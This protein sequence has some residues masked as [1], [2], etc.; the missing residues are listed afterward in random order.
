MRPLRRRLAPLA[1]L[2]LAAPVRAENVE[3][4]FEDVDGLRRGYTVLRV[5]GTPQERG[6]ALGTT[7][8]QELTA[9]LPK[10]RALPGY[11]WS[12]QVASQASWPAEVA[13][14]LAAMA[15]GIR[16]AAPGSTVTLA[17]LQTLNGLDWTFGD[18]CRSHSCWGRYVE[19]PV[20][21][22]ST[23]RL[24]LETPFDL[25]LHHVVVLFE[26]DSGPRW[27]NVAWPGFVTAITAVDARGTLVSL[28]DFEGTQVAR[29][30]VTFRGIA[31]RQALTSPAAG[32]AAARRD[33]AAALLS[34]LPLATS[35][36]LNYYAPE[37]EGGVFTCAAGVGCAAPRRPQPGYFSG[38][39][40]VTSNSQTD[41]WSVPA[42]AEFIDAYYRQGGVKRLADHFALMGGSGLHLV[43]VEYRAESDLTVW[44]HGRGRGDVLR[45]EWGSA[46]V[47]VDTVA[48]KGCGCGEGGAPLPIFAAAALSLGLVRARRASIP[49]GAGPG[50]VGD[51]RAGARRSPRTCR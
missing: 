44:I 41:G 20:R 42:G 6:R 47:G 46:G 17:D 7:F 40:L 16:A 23:R 43:S 9:E 49:A 12:A 37:G 29:P 27:L 14:E 11:A 18:A 30:G 2:L 24:D 50:A 4:L 1:V 13:E 45:L 15:E 33:E 38:E 48:P 51:A 25:A 5:W 28:H 21:T 10:L 39:V 22:L 34:S 32:D 26:P 19:A 3:V 36:F 8:A 31:A 35:T